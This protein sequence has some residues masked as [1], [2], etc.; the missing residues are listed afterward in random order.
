MV[1]RVET[2][3]PPETDASRAT[4]WL[5]RAI[6]IPGLVVFWLVDLAALPLLLA[7]AAVADLARRR[8]FVAVRFHLAL[9]FALLMHV[10]GLVLLLG[11]WLLGALTGRERERELDFR[12]EAWW[13]ATIWRAATGLFGMH[14]EVEGRAELGGGPVIVMARHAS[15]LDVLLPVVFLS[16]GKRALALRYVAKRELLWDPWLDV[17]GHRLPSAFVQRDSREHAREIALVELLACGLGPRDGIVI[18]PEGTRFT[19]AKRTRVLASLARTDEAALAYA[20]RL[21]N[22]LPPHAGGPLAVLERAK[23]ADVVFCAHTGLEGANHMRDLLAGSLIGGTVH[24]R[25]WRIPAREIPE[26]AAARL[27]WLRDWWER[28]DAWIESRRRLAT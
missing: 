14:V 16:S 27:V 26:D 17:V 21:K 18:F 28:L 6:T 23:G 1:G 8:R 15:L 5:R 11:A 10:L 3:A 7:V 4:T 22:L 9:A 19:E 20:T 12:L 2:T 24:V 25:F 13:A